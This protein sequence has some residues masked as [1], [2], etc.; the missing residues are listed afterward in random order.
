MNK[1]E[2]IKNPE[3]RHSKNDTSLKKKFPNEDIPVFLIFC[4]FIKVL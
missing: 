4:E 1:E 2:A 3:R